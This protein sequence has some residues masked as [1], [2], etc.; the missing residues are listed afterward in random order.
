MTRYSRVV[1]REY[2]VSDKES[3]PDDAYLEYLAHNKDGDAI[4]R[5]VVQHHPAIN[6]TQETNFHTGKPVVDDE[7]T[8]TDSQRDTRWGSTPYT[9]YAEPGEQL[10][11]FGHRH[12]PAKR[13]V[14]GLYSENSLAGRTSAMNLIGIANNAST[15]A[16]GKNVVPDKNLSVHSGALVDRLHAEGHISSEDMPKGRTA[17]D[18]MNTHTFWNSGSILANRYMGAYT[19][20]VDTLED[21]SAR[22][23]AART[24]IRDL[25]GSS[26]KGEEHKQLSLW[27]E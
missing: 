15:E 26:K 19:H 23:P 20:G 13:I 12:T 21:L 10:V 3:N 6:D 4:S 7:M 14:T 2:D 22:V 18:V 25:L 11:M 9:R 1:N 27:D 8:H 5:L 17:G 16:I 24:R